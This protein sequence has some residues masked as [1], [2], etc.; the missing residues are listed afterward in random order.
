MRVRLY[1]LVLV[2]VA[3]MPCLAITAQAQPLELAFVAPESITA[4]LSGETSEEV[5]VWLKNSS[6]HS[7]TPEFKTVLENSEGDAVPATVELGKEKSVGADQVARFRVT[8]AG[9]STSSGQLVA[10]VAGVAPA[11]VQMTVAPKL[12]LSRG[13]DGALLIP[14]G[15]S[16][17]VIGAI[18]AWFMVTRKVRLVDPLGAVELDFTKSFASTLTAVGALLGTIISAG[19]LPEQ[20]VYL[21]KAG[22][23]GLNL[24]FGIAVVVA[25][26]VYSMVQRVVPEAGKDPKDWKFRGY[27]LPFLLASLITLWAV[28]GEVWTMWLLIGE[29]G[30]ENGFTDH[31]VAVTRL[32]LAL[33]VIGMI[34]YTFTR[35]GAAVRDKPTSKKERTMITEETVEAD[36]EV[37]EPIKLL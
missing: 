20:T 34:P 36:P 25:G 29:L 24:T 33:A 8:L 31:A 30:H 21:S 3:L 12:D 16:I 13:V 18:A 2:A 6:H 32:L 9:A 28:F 35:V 15:V 14:L 27:V 19:V 11:S 7:V 4:N 5:S 23:T 26:V 10:T 17:L 37:L 22:F 1:L